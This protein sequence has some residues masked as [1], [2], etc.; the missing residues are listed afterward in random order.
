[1]FTKVR[2]HRSVT[3]LVLL[4]ALVGAGLAVTAGAPAQASP[5]SVTTQAHVPPRLDGFLPIGEE[6]KP[7][8]GQVSTH[9]TSGRIVS[10]SI[11]QAKLPSGITATFNPDSTIRVSGTTATRGHYELVVTLTGLSTD[12]ELSKA[13]STRDV[14]VSDSIVIGNPGPAQQGIPVSAQ[15]PL[16]YHYGTVTDVTATSLPAGLS[17][18]PKGLI[19]GTTYDTGTFR[20]AYTAYGMPGVTPPYHAPIST[21]AE[22][23]MVV[24]P[25]TLELPATEMPGA[26][27]RE[28][29]RWQLPI[30]HPA[31]ETVT[32]TA[33]GLPSGLTVSPTGVVSGYATHGGPHRVTF[34]V[35]ARPHGAPWVVEKTTTLPLTVWYP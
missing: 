19:T 33:T 5:D 23:D 28:S 27:W 4:G 3:S 10:V 29:Y 13:T 1:M 12:G 14:I 32:V 9:Y 7:Y 30:Q 8:S 31:D 16:R 11:D 24:A 20:V 35:T 34:T 2:P 26:V 21:T 22:F 17:I 18:S 6:N 15:L 25:W